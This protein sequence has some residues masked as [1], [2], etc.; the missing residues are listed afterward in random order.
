M[1]SSARAARWPRPSPFRRQRNGLRSEKC[2]VARVT[3]TG[4]FDIAFALAAAVN[5][6]GLIGWAF[7]LPKIAPLEWAPGA[8]APGEQVH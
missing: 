7:V 3:P 8:G 2:E 1:R 4:R 6:L 5:V